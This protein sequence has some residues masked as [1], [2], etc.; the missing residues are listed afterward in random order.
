MGGDERRDVSLQQVGRYSWPSLS[1]FSLFLGE[2][3]CASDSVPSRQ[4]SDTLESWRERRQK[5]LWHGD[6]HSTPVG[7]EVLDAVQEEGIIPDISESPE[8]LRLSG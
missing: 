4:P 2:R 8:S 3:R 5:D 6:T 7:N 1:P